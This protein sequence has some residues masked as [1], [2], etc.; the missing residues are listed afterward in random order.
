MSIDRIIHSIRTNK[1]NHLV[2][3]KLRSQTEDF[4]N[5]LFH[6]LFDSEISVSDNI[7]DLAQ[8]F[9]ELH[10]LLESCEKEDCMSIWEK[11]LLELPEILEKLN[12]DA[13][14]ICEHDPAAN[15]VEEVI[16]AYPGFFAIA[17][18]RLSHAFLKNDLPLVPRIM[19]EYAHGL[20]GIDIHP[21]AQIGVPF[22]IDHGTGVVIGQSTIIKDHVKI[23]QGV[24]L[25]ALQVSKE[26]ENQKRHPTV[27]NNVTIYAGS[28]I[29]GGDTVI[30]ENC[31][32]GG[33]VWLTKSVPPNTI[34]YQQV[35]TRLKQKSE[36]IDT[37]NP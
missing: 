22:F 13:K 18:Y 8:S 6:M 12:R 20:T 19:S 32:I 23:Y 30:G 24:T 10:C 33:N 4:T 29:L 27:E 5:K 31:T 21:G 25:G 16:L 15:S 35:D 37:P 14:C 2:N 3:F 34:V 11:F 36:K 17:V 26:M 7:E 9:Y 28:T 1:Q